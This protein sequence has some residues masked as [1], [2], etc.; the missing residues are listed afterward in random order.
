VRA[1]ERIAVEPVGQSPQ[2]LEAI[3]RAN[4]EFSERSANQLKLPVAVLIEQRDAALSALAE[5]QARAQEAREKLVLEQDS[6][7]TFLMGEHEQKQADLKAEFTEQVRSVQMERAIRQS[8]EL[9]AATVTAPTGSESNAGDE[10]KQLL[11]AA[12]AE[13]DDT[14]ADASRLQDERDEAIRAVDDVKLEAYSEVEK[15]R[16]EAFQIQTEL[17]ETHRLLEDARDASRD[18]TLEFAEELDQARR[19][20][21]ERNEEVRRLRGRL[22]ELTEEARH[23]RPPPPPASGDLLQAREEAQTLRRQLIEAKREMSRLARELALATQVRVKAP[24]AKR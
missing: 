18:R 16:D 2:A 9:P 21:D 19:S 10:L 14:R 8:R 4:A 3:R 23:S 5:A 17:D 6:F 7:I 22:S 24:S 15:A 12:Y 1:S 13:I 20:L 11:E